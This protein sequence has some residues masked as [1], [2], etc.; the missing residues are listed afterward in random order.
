MLG[1]LPSSELTASTARST[2]FFAFAAVS[3]VSNSRN[4]SAAKLVAAQVRKSFAVMCSPV[5]S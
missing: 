5:I 2:F 4:A 3:Y 1:V